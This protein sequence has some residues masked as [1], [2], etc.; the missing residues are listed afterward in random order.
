[1]L[2]NSGR[3]GTYKDES[4]SIFLCIPHGRTFAPLVVSALGA[5]HGDFVLR[6]GCSRVPVQYAAWK[7]QPDIASTSR[8]MLKHTKLQNTTLAP[9][10]SLSRCRSATA[11]R[12][13]EGAPPTETTSTLQPKFKSAR[14]TLA[15]PGVL[16]GTS[17]RR[18]PSWMAHRPCQRH[19]RGQRA[20]VA[21]RH[22]FQQ[23][24]DSHSV[25]SLG[26]FLP[27]HALQKRP[28]GQRAVLVARHLFET[29]KHRT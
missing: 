14:P 29:M 15:C 25:H 9:H 5:M 20:V 23:A 22:L 16:R 4:K 7:V 1:M 27:R 3:L 21:D 24:N 12:R 8:S 6:W 17:R 2:P 28:R 10:P 19:A 18:Q 13:S 11:T 26:T